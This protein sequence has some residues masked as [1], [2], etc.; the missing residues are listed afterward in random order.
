MCCPLTVH[1]RGLVGADALAAMPPG[2]YVINVGRGPV[3]DYAALHD[4][5]ASEQLAGAGIDVAWSEPID[6]ADEL[7]T[8]NVTA[9]PHIG[10][11]T[12]ES[13]T[14][15]AATFARNVTNLAT[16]QSLEHRAD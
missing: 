3:V 11:V 8:G 9:T 12:T 14:A 10:G 13:Y 4:A 7:L 16:G 6:P 1:T 15:M 2:G 5:L